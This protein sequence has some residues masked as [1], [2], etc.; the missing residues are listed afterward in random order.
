MEERKTIEEWSKEYEVVI[1]DPDGFDRTDINLYSR[2][3]TREEFE[4][5]MAFSTCLF[6][7]IRIPKG[8]VG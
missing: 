8:D 7:A 2:L 3:F 5:G 1:Y 4:K 6:Q